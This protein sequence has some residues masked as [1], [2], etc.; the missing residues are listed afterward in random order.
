MFYSADLLEACIDF[1]PNMEASGF[2]D[3]VTLLATG[4]SVGE[5][6]VSF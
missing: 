6:V 2:I 4:G 5:G 3:D 1:H